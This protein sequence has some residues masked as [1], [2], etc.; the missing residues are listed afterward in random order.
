MDRGGR[1]GPID[2]QP[3]SNTTPIC[4]LGRYRPLCKWEALEPQHFTHILMRHFVLGIDASDEGRR[5]TQSCPRLNAVAHDFHFGVS[6]RHKAAASCA[7]QAL[8][9]HTLSSV[10]LCKKAS[11]LPAALS[12]EACAI[13][14][15]VFL[16]G[17]PMPILRC[18]VVGDSVDLP[19]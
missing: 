17:Q 7:G 8:S 15:C 19:S 12:A 16:G 10:S 9:T 14:E 1:G 4:K 2:C 5:E 6:S 3:T 13:V 18:F 11:P